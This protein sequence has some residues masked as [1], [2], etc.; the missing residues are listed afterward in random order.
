[1]SSIENETFEQLKLEN[2][3]IQTISAGDAR[4]FQLTELQQEL[5]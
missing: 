5:I 4:F 2:Q 3:M 1:M